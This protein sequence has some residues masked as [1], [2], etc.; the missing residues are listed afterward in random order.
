MTVLTMHRHA[1]Q[2]L[3]KYIA[4]E[5]RRH[6]DSRR[7]MRIAVVGGRGIPSTYSGVETIVENLF[8]HFASRGHHVTVYCRPGVLDEPA[9]IYRGMQLVRT[10][11]VPGKLETVSH[12]AISL[13]HA[14]KNGALNCDGEKFDLVSFH[15]IPPNIAQKIPAAAGIPAISHVHG[16]DHQRE[17]WKGIGARIILQGEREMV[18][19]AAQIVTVNR[20]IVRYYREQY[21]VEAALLP[22]GI[23]PVK[24]EFTPDAATLQKFGLEPGKF[25]VT[26]SRLVP[27]K[28]HNDVLAA[29]A[30]VKTDHKLVIVGEGN[31][32]DSYV[33]AIKKQAAS[34]PR[35]IFTGLQKGEALQ[36]LFR[37]AAL[38]LTASELEGLPSSLLECMDR[39]VC[40]IVSNIPPHAEVMEGV[41]GYD[42]M[43]EVGDVEKLQQSIEMCLANPGHAHELARR[44]RS[45]VRARYAWPVLAAQTEDLYREVLAR[46]F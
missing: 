3:S 29:F 12:T 46:S 37:C 31:Q 14:V 2:P 19:H 18:K 16:L 41:A 9:A 6:I 40:A 20:S 10:G 43:F 32:S 25:L 42:L 1:A 15:A 23:H 35:V 21:G 28:R 33:D 26:I 17:K 34:D 38:Y 4:P 36:T 22:N 7:P 24:D 5:P 30:K 11:I 39:Q 44:M 45:Y 13:L 8:A 27:E